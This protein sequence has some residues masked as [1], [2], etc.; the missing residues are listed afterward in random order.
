MLNPNEYETTYLRRWVLVNNGR[1]MKTRDPIT[2]TTNLQQALVLHSAD[3][4]RFPNF[5]K[6]RV[7]VKQVKVINNLEII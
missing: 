2:W 6:A 5:E 1:Y 3:V 7:R 4:F